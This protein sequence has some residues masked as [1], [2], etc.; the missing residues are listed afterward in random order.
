MESVVFQ[1]SDL[2]NVW[3]AGWMHCLMPVS[4]FLTRFVWNAD[5]F[6]LHIQFGSM[7]SIHL[8]YLCPGKNAGIA[9]RLI[10]IYTDHQKA[11]SYLLEL[12][13]KPLRLVQRGEH[14]APYAEETRLKATSA[15]FYGD[16]MID[17]ECVRSLFDPAKVYR[18]S[19]NASGEISISPIAFKGF[20]KNATFAAEFKKSKLPTKSGEIIK[21]GT[22]VFGYEWA[23]SEWANA[24]LSN[25]ERM[26]YPAGQYGYEEGFVAF[27][28]S[29]ECE[30]VAR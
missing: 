19:Y 3:L 9:H 14:V 13:G 30:V 6:T 27:A 2:Q 21:R 7:R 11:R 26:L 8:G 16:K 18:L 25:D 23:R 17:P 10:E 1:Q 24:T 28:P 20:I 4:E 22:L 12:Q 5:D 15:N 29:F